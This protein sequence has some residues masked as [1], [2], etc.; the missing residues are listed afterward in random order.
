M[1]LN[2]E[3]ALAIGLAGGMLFLLAIGI[4]QFDAGLIACAVAIGASVMLLLTES[5]RHPGRACSMQAGK[6][7]SQA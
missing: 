6:F 1:R 5:K 4:I 3:G 2:R 7:R